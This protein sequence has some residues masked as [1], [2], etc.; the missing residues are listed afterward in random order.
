MV[1]NRKNIIP[2]PNIRR[3]R[4]A[5]AALSRDFPSAKTP[6]IGDVDPFAI[7][8]DYLFFFDPKTKLRTPMDGNELGPSPPTFP[9]G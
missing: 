9:H 3:T 4:D 8:M 1:T 6:G 2:D 7:F 5:A